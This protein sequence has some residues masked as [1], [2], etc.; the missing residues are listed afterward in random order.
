M[1]L[2][3]T[4]INSLICK[5]RKSFECMY[6]GQD[7][8]MYNVMEFLRYICILNEMFLDFDNMIIDISNSR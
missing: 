7:I 3:H 1:S 5:L 2:R 6:D 4:K 8:P